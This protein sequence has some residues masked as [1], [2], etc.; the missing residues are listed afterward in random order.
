[1]NPDAWT[2]ADP[3]LTHPYHEAWHTRLDCLGL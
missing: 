1:M 3:P 2:H